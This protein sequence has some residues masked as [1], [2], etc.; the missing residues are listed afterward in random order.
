VHRNSFKFGAEF[1]FGA[2]KVAGLLHSPQAA[3]RGIRNWMSS[4]IVPLEEIA[5]AVVT[6]VRD[7]SPL[8]RS[9]EVRPTGRQIVDLRPAPGARR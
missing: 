8:G 2:P 5:D 9:I 7:D 6:L 3:E 1:S 4:K